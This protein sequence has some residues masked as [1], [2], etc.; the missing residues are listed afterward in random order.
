M[1]DEQRPRMVLA[2]PHPEKPENR[3][4]MHSF[5]KLPLLDLLASALR[6]DTLRGN[7]DQK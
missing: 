5:K 1:L 3:T 6:A 7:L 4:T 2:S